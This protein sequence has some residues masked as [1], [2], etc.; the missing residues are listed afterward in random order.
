MAA[1][2]DPSGLA[3]PLILLGSIRVL[4]FFVPGRRFDS[5]QPIVDRLF[6]SSGLIVSVMV[7]GC[8]QDI[9]DQIV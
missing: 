8:A 3:K 2:C 7:A 6:S 5:L 9:D 4:L 1:F